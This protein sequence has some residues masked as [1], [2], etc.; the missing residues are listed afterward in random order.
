MAFARFVRPL[1]HGLLA[2]VLFPV[3]GKHIQLRVGIFRVGRNHGLIDF[4]APA[5][6]GRNPV[7]T[8][9]DSG[10]LW[11]EL[12]APGYIVIFKCFQNKK[13]RNVGA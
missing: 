7:E 4:D 1:D 12:L 2:H 5:R 11:S 9:L 8:I 13:V 6:S 10:R 3:T